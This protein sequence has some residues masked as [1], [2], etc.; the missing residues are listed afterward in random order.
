[1]TGLGI[2][3]N[4]TNRIRQFKSQCDSQHARNVL[5]YI[6]HI[7]VINTIIGNHFRNALL[8]LVL[9][10]LCNPI[11]ISVFEMGWLEYAFTKEKPWNDNRDAKHK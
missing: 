4:P 7:L 5:V 6:R 2:H 11:K 9:G 10:T 8:L 3:T 1:M